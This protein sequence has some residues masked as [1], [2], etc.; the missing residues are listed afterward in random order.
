MFDLLIHGGTVIDGSGKPGFKADVGIRDE[1]IALIAPTITEEAK[2]VIDASGFVVSPGFIDIHSHSDLTPFSSIIIWTVKFVRALP[3]RS[4]AIVGFP[5]CRS[6]IPAGQPSRS[7]ME[8]DWN[9]PWAICYSRI[10]TSVIIR[11]MLPNAPM[12]LIWAY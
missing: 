12:P 4:S 7:S 9:F 10:M 6:M 5:V 8:P 1:R 11:N 3:W 2:E